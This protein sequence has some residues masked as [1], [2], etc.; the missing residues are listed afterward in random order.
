MIRITLLA[1]AVALSGATA[2]TAQ[3]CPSEPEFVG[4]RTGNANNR[5]AANAIAR[6]ELDVAR[7]FAEQAAYSRSA[8]SVRGAG[9]ANLCAVAALQGDAETA[10]EACDRAVEMRDTNWRAYNN[11]GAA[12]WLAGDYAAANADFTRAAELEAGEDAV[13]ANL[14]LSQCAAS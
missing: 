5:A 8:P 1:V 7:H 14:R 2:A 3:S 11:R 13:T 4:H 6:G 9:F 12:L 10:T